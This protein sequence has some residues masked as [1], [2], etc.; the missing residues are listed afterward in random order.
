MFYVL[1]R[2]NLSQKFCPWRKNDKYCMCLCVEKLLLGISVKSALDC[3]FIGTWTFCIKEMTAA[4][5]ERCLNQLA[6]FTKRYI[7][8]SFTTTILA[9]WKA[10]ISY[11]PP[12]KKSEVWQGKIFFS[13]TGSSIP[14]LGQ[15]LAYCHFRIL[16]QRVTFETS[17]PSDIWSEWCQ[18]KKTKR[19]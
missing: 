13:C 17:D 12:L 6:V 9:M 18:D 1:C 4:W 2:E 16:T 11:T 3:H 8:I 15:W 7:L 5:L 14:D 10:Q 19:Q